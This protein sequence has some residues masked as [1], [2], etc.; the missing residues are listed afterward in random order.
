MWRNET[1]NQLNTELHALRL[2]LEGRHLTFKLQIK[3]WKLLER[4]EVE[5]RN[6]EGSPLLRLLS[7]ESSMSVKDYTNRKKY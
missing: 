6:K 1:D 7:Y 5:L 2:K 3:C 4:V